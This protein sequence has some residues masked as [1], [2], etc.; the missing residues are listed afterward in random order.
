[1][2]ELDLRVRGA[3]AHEAALNVAK[4]LAEEYGT[5]YEMYRVKP[6]ELQPDGRWACTVRVRSWCPNHSKTEV[7]DE[8][9]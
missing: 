9:S 6:L 8:H 3:N 5:P 7:E 1:M 2:D 4:F